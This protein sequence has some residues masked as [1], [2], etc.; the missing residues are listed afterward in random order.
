MN[1]APWNSE[2]VRARPSWSTSV[3][4]IAVSGAPPGSSA[5]RA[6]RSS[7]SPDER[8]AEPRSVRTGAVG[9]APQPMRSARTAATSSISAT[10]TS[11]PRFMADAAPSV[12]LHA[13]VGRHLIQPHATRLDVG[14]GVVLAL[15]L[16]ARE[17]AKHGELTR[18]RERVGNTA[19][20]HAPRLPR[21]RL[22]RGEVVVHAA[23]RGEEAGDLRV[24]CERRG[25]VPL[26]L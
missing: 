25:V 17:P 8:P 5:A 11:A 14:L 10:R 15:H 23:N 7:P 21:D 18:V 20:K 16:V 2:S 26:G 24:P 6:A 4:A 13:G 19:L 9:R 22:P 3:P 1:G 12:E